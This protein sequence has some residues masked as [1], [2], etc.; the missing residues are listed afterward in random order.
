MFRRCASST[1]WMSWSAKSCGSETS[2]TSARTCG[3]RPAMLLRTGM[4]APLLASHSAGQRHGLGLRLRGDG[5]LVGGGQIASLDVGQF[6]GLLVHGRLA[7]GQ[8][9]LLDAA[10]DAVPVEQVAG[11]S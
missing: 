8:I 9:P 7:G 10:G 11:Y 2:P 5:L 3:T 6:C 4:P 1:S